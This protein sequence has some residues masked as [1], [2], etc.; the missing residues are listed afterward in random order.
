MKE[1]EKKKESNNKPEPLAI[2]QNVS[3]TTVA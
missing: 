2:H 3:I 1:K